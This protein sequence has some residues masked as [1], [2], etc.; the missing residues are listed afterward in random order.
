MLP[1]EGP[2]G[3]L[4]VSMHPPTQS[5]DG[6]EL[7]ASGPEYQIFL[8]INHH[9]AISFSNT[10]HTAE[11][12]REGGAYIEREAERERETDREIETDREG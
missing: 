12:E 10:S 8:N 6:D 3:S 1:P 2:P 9:S 11:R 4:R 7:K 5:T